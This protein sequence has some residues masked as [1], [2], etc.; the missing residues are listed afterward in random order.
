[1][2]LIEFILLSDMGPN[3]YAFVWYSVNGGFYKFL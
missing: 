2:S 3:I 1:L